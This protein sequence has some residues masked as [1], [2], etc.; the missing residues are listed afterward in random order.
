[1]IFVGGWYGL[2]LL[3]AA[4]VLLARWEYVVRKYPERFSS[5]TNLCLNCAHCPERL[6]HHK[7]QLR[8][9]WKR[10]KPKF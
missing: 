3:G 5:D 10:I 1:M 7:K 4:L 2:S 8:V 6:C 9:L